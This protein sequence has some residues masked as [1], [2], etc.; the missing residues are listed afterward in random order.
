M[1]EYHADGGMGPFVDTQITYCPLGMD[2]AASPS[3]F[4]NFKHFT[5]KDGLLLIWPS[6][7]GD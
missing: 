6:R 5:V 1:A 4:L 3:C 7:H 2:Q